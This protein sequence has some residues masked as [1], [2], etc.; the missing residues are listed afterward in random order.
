MI[1]GRNVFGQPI[2]IDI[3]TYENIRKIVTG[4]RDDSKNWLFVRFSSFHR[5]L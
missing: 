4:Q 3:K 1:C 2:N 5:E